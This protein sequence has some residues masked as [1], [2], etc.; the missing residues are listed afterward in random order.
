MPG[1]EDP[2]I[3]NLK[4]DLVGKTI[5]DYYHIDKIIGQGGMSIVYLATQVLLQKKYAIKMLHSHLVNNEITVQRF[6][7]EGKAICELNHPNIITIHSFGTYNDSQ[8]YLVMDY[9]EGVTLSQYI[10]EHGFVPVNQ[11]LLIFKQIAKALA[12]A[13]SKNI[14]HRDL[15]PSNIMLV[16]DYDD[17]ITVKILDFGIAK[18]ISEN[19]NVAK[20]TSTGEVFGSPY[21]MS[22]EQCKGSKLD[23]RSDIYSFGCLMYETLTGQLPFK[24]SNLI[25]TFNL[26]IS[27]TPK[28]FGIACRN[29][30][31]PSN[32]EYIVFKALEKNP[33]QRFE[34]MTDLYKVLDEIDKKNQNKIYD[35][36]KILQLKLKFRHQLSLST[37]TIFFLILTVIL[38]GFSVYAL[39]QYNRINKLCFNNEDFKLM[40]LPYIVPFKLSDSEIDLKK[41]T[42]NNP[43]LLDNYIESTKSLRQK[44]DNSIDNKYYSDILS[45]SRDLFL[46]LNEPHYGLSNKLVLNN[47]KFKKNNLYPLDSII[48]PPSA[49]LLLNIDYALNQSPTLI[50]PK[51][52]A[53]L[54]NFREFVNTMPI[55][56]Y[57]NL[58][59]IAD[60]LGRYNLKLESDNI[61]D[62]TVYFLDNIKAQIDKNSPYN[63]FVI[64]SYLYIAKNYFDNHQYKKADDIYE[65]IIN[66]SNYDFLDNTIVYCKAYAY[67]QVAIIY[68]LAKI[69]PPQNSY[70][71]ALGYDPL[72]DYI[73]CGSTAWSTLYTK[74]KYR[75]D[76]VDKAKIF[77]HNIMVNAIVSAKRFESYKLYE[78]SIIDYSQIS[79]ILKLKLNSPKTT[80]EEADEYKIDIARIK[81]NMAKDY[82][83]MGEYKYALKFYSE[84]IDTL[85]SLKNSL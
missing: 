34:S 59:T 32:I 37:L 83:L 26:Q 29:I 21:Y 6:Q 22:P 18:I 70:N 15:K 16:K 58:N 55:N 69:L 7:N 33:K 77:L 62:L 19:D 13:H 79:N 30:K 53:Q 63:D 11:A 45:Q 17:N 14:I 5:G 73:Q 84:A 56:S 20:L 40:S 44:I 78:E 35:F 42:K 23:A 51:T 39:L 82:F 41:I 46:I 64:Q 31:L 68:N 2:N 8:P 67:T 47:N 72:S 12:F 71:L 76:S 4:S 65:K 74:Y 25:D 61:N 66:F 28:P 54:K 81:I 75:S 38:T 24:G 80:T 9:L 43:K 50:E 3:L 52:R 27:E 85:D 49:K 48:N 10:E 1:Y 36:F 60:L 57:N